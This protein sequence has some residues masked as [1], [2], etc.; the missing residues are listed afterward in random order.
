MSLDWDKFKAQ[1]FHY[2]TSQRAPCSD[3]YANQCALRVSR[4]LA[5][6]GWPFNGPSQR[7][8]ST[9]FGPMCTHNFARGAKTLADY[10]EVYLKPP[11]RYVVPKNPKT[12]RLEETIAGTYD[13]TPDSAGN[14]KFYKAME[15]LQKRAT[16]GERLRGIVF[17]NSPEH[18]DGFDLVDGTNTKG[19]YG[20]I[21]E[22]Y[23]NTS[24]E[25]RV[26]F[27]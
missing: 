27:L 7:Y 1:Q 17:F 9:R 26:F 19:P 20:V 10:L 3:P 25:V 2:V 16:D 21:G 11:K 12:R 14:H 13:P 5:A 6:A 8:T 24:T 22:Q 4:S 15:W 18:I 23:G